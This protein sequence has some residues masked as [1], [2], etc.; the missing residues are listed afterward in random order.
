MCQTCV[1]DYVIIENKIMCLIIR[2]FEWNYCSQYLKVNTIV[3]SMNEL[4]VDVARMK[5][6]DREKSKCFVH[7]YIK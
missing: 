3:I 5:F 7:D 2:A 6:T 4:N 1:R